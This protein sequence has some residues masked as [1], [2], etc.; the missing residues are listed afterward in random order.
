MSIEIVLPIPKT[1]APGRVDGV[2]GGG[3]PKRAHPKRAHPMVCQQVFDRGRRNGLAAT[4]R[5]HVLAQI[6]HVPAVLK[7]P[8]Y[9]FHS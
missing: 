8:E 5:D 2:A 4:G 7:Q 6:Q 9:F 3:G 1:K